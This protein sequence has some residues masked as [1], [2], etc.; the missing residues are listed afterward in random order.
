MKID[1]HLNCQEYANMKLARAN[2]P[3]CLVAD[4]FIIA[5]GGQ[6]SSSSFTKEVEIYNIN[7]N[8]WFQ[9]QPLSVPRANTSMA[10]FGSRH[11]FIFNGF[12]NQYQSTQLNCIEYLD[13]V[14]LD[15]KTMSATQWVTLTIGNISDIHQTKPS[16]SAVL[17]D[18]EILIFG[19]DLKKTYC[20]DARSVLQG[21]NA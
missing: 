4:R 3:L 11:I 8:K 13:L 16:G 17:S 21:Q 9:G 12:Q 7:E 19:G 18:N 14:S 1:E 2:T 10:K 15:Q 6:I 20:I 5:A